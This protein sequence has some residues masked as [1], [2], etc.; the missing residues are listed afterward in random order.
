[1]KVSV[2]YKEYKQY[3]VESTYNRGQPCLFDIYLSNE[4]NEDTSGSIEC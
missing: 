4:N 2:T 3:S 1:M